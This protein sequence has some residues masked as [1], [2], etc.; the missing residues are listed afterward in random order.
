MAKGSTDAYIVAKSSKS[1]TK[2]AYETD[3]IQTH[4]VRLHN[5]LRSREIG[6]SHRT[7]Q[8][9]KKTGGGVDWW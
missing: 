1:Q 6:E 8:K 2:D 4:A 7:L 5:L 9:K 3:G